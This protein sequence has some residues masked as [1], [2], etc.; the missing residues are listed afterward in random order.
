MITNNKP[1]YFVTKHRF[2][3]KI[4]DFLLLKRGRVAV[5]DYFEEN[6]QNY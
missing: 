2:V 3:T 1:L 6:P 5:Y 4:G